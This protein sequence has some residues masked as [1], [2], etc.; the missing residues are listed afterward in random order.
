MLSVG[1]DGLFFFSYLLFYSFILESLAY[2]SLHYTYY[3]FHCT[4]YSH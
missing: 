2:Y 4:Y 3:S 1:P